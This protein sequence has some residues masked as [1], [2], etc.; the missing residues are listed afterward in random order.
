MQVETWKP[1]NNCLGY[2][3]SDLGRIRGKKGG[4]IKLH[5]NKSN[6]RYW[7]FRMPS[8]NYGKTIHRIVAEHF[9]DNPDNKPEVNHKWGDKS[10]NRACSLE[11]V[12]HKENMRH[13][14]DTG[15]KVNKGHAKKFDSVT[16][17]IIKECF[18]KKYTNVAIAKYFGCHQS[19]ISYIRQGKRMYYTL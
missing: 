13:A 7:V 15:L 1:I 12:T 3:V 4:I 6:G 5:R 16:F 11:W 18:E 10:D 17:D 14:H 19:T 8:M 2:F 9:V